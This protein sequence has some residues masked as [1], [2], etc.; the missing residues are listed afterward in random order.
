MYT[1]TQGILAVSGKEVR[2]WDP[3]TSLSSIPSSTQNRTLLP[4]L[5][6]YLRSQLSAVIT[7]AGYQKAAQV[8]TSLT[9]E[10][11]SGLQLIVNS[12][13]ELR[14]ANYTIRDMF[15]LFSPCGDPFMAKGMTDLF[16][17]GG[18]AGEDSSDRLLLCT[19]ELGLSH[20][21]SGDV[22]KD[23]KKYVIHLKPKVVLQSA[24]NYL[25]K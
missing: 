16:N 18:K 23:R 24:V 21:D 6:A 14:E 13:S 20:L 3:Q 12:V 4:S 9:E 5:T 10:S 25:I 17:S 15:V 7:I 22:K 11:Q 8:A 19:A 2:F 1:T